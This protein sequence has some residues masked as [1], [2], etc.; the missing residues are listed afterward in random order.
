MIP[1]VATSQNWRKNG[2]KKKKNNCDHNAVPKNPKQ[3]GQIK[4]VPI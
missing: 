2:E 4:S 1:N 3:G